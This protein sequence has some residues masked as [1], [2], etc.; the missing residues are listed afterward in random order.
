[1]ASR[2]RILSYS[3]FAVLAVGLG[4]GMALLILHP[5]WKDRLAGR[6]AGKTELAEASE[7]PDSP[8]DAGSAPKRPPRADLKLWE[9]Y[10][11]QPVEKIIA[12]I[13]ATHPPGEDAA[14]PP[15]EAL[16][17]LTPPPDA[18]QFPFF[19]NRQAGSGID[20]SP[21]SGDCAVADLNG[22]HFPDI[23]HVSAGGNGTLRLFANLGGG[24]F[25]DASP[26]FGVASHP[27]GEG[28]LAGDFDND[29]DPDLFVLRGDRLPNSLLEN[30]GGETCRDVTETAGLLDFF[31]S[32]AAA[33]TDYDQDGRLDLCV[34]N[35]N[36]D[37][38]DP[39]LQL[40]H[41]SGDGTFKDLARD[42]QLTPANPAN[43]CAWA[44]INGDGYPELFLLS[45]S[46]GPVVFRS[47][48]ADAP[49]TWR[50][51]EITAGAGLESF[52]AGG[53][54]LTWDLDNDGFADLAGGDPLRV[55]HG[56]EGGRFED[57]TEALEIAKVESVLSV[58]AADLDGDGSGELIAGTGDG[59]P[60][61]VFGNRNGDRFRDVSEASGIGFARRTEKIVPADLDLDGDTDLLVLAGLTPGGVLMNPGQYDHR[62][63]RLS[64]EGKT[65]NRSALGARVSLVVRDLDWVLRP[66]ER[67]V[68]APG[69][70]EIGLGAAAKIESVSITWPVRGRPTSEFKD[71][72]MDCQVRIREGEKKF[73]K[74]EI[75]PPKPPGPPRSRN[76]A[77]G[78]P[79]VAP[80]EPPVKASE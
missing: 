6:I 55:F 1:M 43:G 20:L 65:A 25:R 59:A 77:G 38:E 51:E 12:A 78:T 10:R 60:N 17:T 18:P 15:M 56:S 37:R 9:Q 40:F 11:G 63:L 61:R 7:A 50:F 52:P 22:D 24:K 66:V 35:D 39:R 30:A 46:A 3:I 80:A 14:P 34:L 2:S 62:W 44:D 74:I 26:G 13:R 68:T 28:V 53:P 5:E 8:P 71:V 45:E 31:D 79:P 47:V 29:G 75:T 64:L 67:V 48:P 72:P 16:E 54:L 42:A 36:G 21:G 41:N 32:K 76:D 69:P 58:A 33:W 19:E 4:A 57:I 73:E 27:G 23:V 70:L 49:E